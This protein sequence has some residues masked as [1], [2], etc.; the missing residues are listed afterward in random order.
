VPGLF[1]GEHRFQIERSGEGEVRSRQAEVFRGVLVHLFPKSMY[2][3]TECG[4]DAMNRALKQRVESQ[5]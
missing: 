5:K 3:K 4:F 1:D 2:E